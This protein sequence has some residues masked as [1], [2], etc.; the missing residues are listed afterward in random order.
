MNK[1]EEYSAKGIFYSLG[2]IALTFPLPFKLSNPWIITMLISWLIH[3]FASRKG[4]QFIS[5]NRWI[6]MSFWSLT[7]FF[8]WHLFS[9]LFAEDFDNSLK[10]IEGKLSLLVFPLVL[11][12]TSLRKDQIHQLLKLFILSICLAILYLM[13][14]SFMNYLDEGF[15]LTYHDFTAPFSAHAVFFSYYLFAAVLFSIYF[16][17]MQGTS[18]KMKGFYTLVIII[19]IVGLVFCA[20]KNVTVVSISFGF[21]MF[22]QRYIKKGVKVKELSIAVVVLLIALFSAMQL[23]AVKSR[24]GELFSGSGMENYHEIRGGGMIEEAETVLFN[25]TSLRITFWY[26]G[27]DEVSERNRL[28]VGLTPGDRREIMNE[29]YAEVGMVSFSN[30]NLHNQFI[31]TFV[32][33]GLIGLLIYLLVYTSL[34]SLAFEQSN[35]LLLI[36]LLATVIFQLTESMLERNKVIVFMMFFFGLL[37]QLT[38][39]P[40]NEN[41]NTGD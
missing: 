4:F 36:F 6:K 14:H 39:A 26:L 27:I 7:I 15:W 20:S 24:M 1:L 19:S 5:D 17:Q 10:A 18:M 16:I 23:D 40:E 21:F 31:Q 28:L 22:I 34:F 13:G 37:Q 11:F 3:L 12:T 41:R 32:E 29:R 2:L 9:L 8:V 35:R 38:F 30:Y 33:L 25:G